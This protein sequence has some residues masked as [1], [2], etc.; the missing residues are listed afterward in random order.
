M[1][2]PRHAIRNE[3]FCLEQDLLFGVAT[4]TTVGTFNPKTSPRQPCMLRPPRQ[5]LSKTWASA[6]W[7]DDLSVLC[8]FTQKFPFCPPG[9]IYPM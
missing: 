7:V 4:V 9:F 8:V 3:A 1:R 2:M 6:T 5:A